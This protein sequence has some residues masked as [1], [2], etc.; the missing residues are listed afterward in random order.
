MKLQIGRFGL[1]LVSGEV[2][3]VDSSDNSKITIVGRTAYANFPE[4]LVLRQQILGYAG[5]SD[6]SFVPV[7]W[8]EYPSITGYYRVTGV[9][10][11]GQRRLAPRGKLTF[12][13]DLERVQ[14]Y[15]APLIEST[16]LGA[17]RTS[18]LALTPRRWLGVPLSAKTYMDYV[19][20]VYGAN[21]GDPVRQG[22]SGDVSIMTLA[23]ANSFIG[24]F[25]LEPEDF[26]DGAATLRVGAAQ[27]VVVGRQIS[28][29]PTAWTISNGI[30]E[31]RSAEGTGFMLEF[32]KWNGTAWGDWKSLTF[33]AAP[34]SLPPNVVLPQPHT[35]TVL[36]NSPEAVSIRLLT[37]VQDVRP[38]MVDLTLRRGARHVEVDQ[39]MPGTRFLTVSLSSFA[40][41]ATLS[42]GFSSEIS[43]A[44]VLFVGSALPS[45]MSGSDY[46][47][48]VG[49]ATAVDH[50]PFCFGIASTTDTPQTQLNEYFWAGSEKMNV[51]AR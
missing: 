3:S 45:S 49:A 28:N 36:S 41:P 5:G 33:K 37:V 10:V 40:S 21:S 13:V 39:R 2:Q 51:V 17:L 30:I 43:A 44:E 42:G 46:K 25:Y 47:P 48:W 1:D 8:E 15:S 34:S 27:N 35:I 11:D 26:Y 31:V 24:Q 22:E 4:S 9:T 12:S 6:E 19:A 14:G 38:M 7:V 32:R 50:F 20:G 23:S 18:A 16:V 29:L